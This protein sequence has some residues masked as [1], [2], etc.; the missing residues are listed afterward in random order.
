MVERRLWM[1]I[2]EV[3]GAD[4][5]DALNLFQAFFTTVIVEKP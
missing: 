5:V 4:P 2:A 3:M 1:G